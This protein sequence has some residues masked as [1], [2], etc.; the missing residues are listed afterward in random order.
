MKTDTL[1]LVTKL[2][3]YTCMGG[4]APL[5][6][7]LT[8]WVDSGQWPPAINWVVIV[9]GCIG[10]AATQVLAFLSQSYGQWV[11]GRTNGNGAPAPAPATQTK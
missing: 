6:T 10:G 5:T 1:V 2:L 7:G 8:Q 3:C 4:L 9:A 11:A